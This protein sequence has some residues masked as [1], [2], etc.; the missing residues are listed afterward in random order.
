MP[1]VR[2]CVG[3]SY[4]IRIHR[5]SGTRTED[6]GEAITQR[7][8]EKEEGGGRAKGTGRGAK[9][10]VTE[11]NGGRG[12]DSIDFNLGPD[13]R[14]AGV[15]E[16][17]K[18]GEEEGRVAAVRRLPGGVGGEGGG[19]EEQAKRPT[20][21]TGR[22]GLPCANTRAGPYEEWAGPTLPSSLTHYLISHSP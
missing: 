6:E 4:S 16:E 15:R 9:R 1:S 14:A 7:G 19:L 22:E 20:P 8:G 2:V 12:E 17:A 13:T 5:S 11:A 3:V 21:T 18:E 10:A